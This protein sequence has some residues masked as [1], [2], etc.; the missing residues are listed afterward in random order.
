M[1]LIKRCNCL[2]HA[3]YVHMYYSSHIPHAQAGAVV[4]HTFSPKLCYHSPC[5]L[6]ETFLYSDLLE[7]RKK[8]WIDAAVYVVLRYVEGVSIN[9]LN[10]NAVGLY[11]NEIE[12]T[13]NSAKYN[14]LLKKKV[15]PL[16]HSKF[17]HLIV[18]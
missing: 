12:G 13:L 9:R 5:S 10:R 17:E 3:S 15:M 8:N 4:V 7:N 16:L 14:K 1:M 11:L 2:L 6:Q 18:Y